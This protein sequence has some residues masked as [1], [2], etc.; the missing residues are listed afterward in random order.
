MLALAAPAN[1]GEAVGLAVGLLQVILAVVAMRGLVEHRRRFP[2]LMLLGVFFAARGVDRI[3][4]AFR[5]GDNAN[6]NLA[7]DGL[8]V[9]ILVLLILRL[10]DTV[11]GLRRAE[12]AA[13]WNRGE[14]ERALADYR[15]LVRH[16]LANPLTILRG[17]VETLASRDRE[18][19]PEDRTRVLSVLRGE[20]DRLEATTLEPQPDRPEERALEP[21][22]RPRPE[23][24]ERPVEG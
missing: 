22:P 9:V 1:A 17:A 23:G 3:L 10:D 19:A 5:A 16:R 11:D 8:T 2:W 14:Y 15:T 18:L 6:V 7:T 4:L 24:S 12:D 21:A 20:L 13:V